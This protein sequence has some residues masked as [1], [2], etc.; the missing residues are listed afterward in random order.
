MH[1]GMGVEAS[2]G[3]KALQSIESTILLRDLVEEKDSSRY[4]GHLRR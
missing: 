3:Y 2:Q 1:A 4:S